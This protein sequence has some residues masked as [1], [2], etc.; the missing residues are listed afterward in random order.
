MRLTTFTLWLLL[1][2]LPSAFV[3]ELLGSWFYGP[4]FCEIFVLDRWSRFG[5]FTS[6]RRVVPLL[7]D[8]GRRMLL[9]P[10]SNCLVGHVPYWNRSLE[11][12]WGRPGSCWILVWVVLGKL[13]ISP[14]FSS[15]QWRFLAGSN[16]GGLPKTCI[17]SLN[18]SPTYIRFQETR[19][20]ESYSY[21]HFASF[22]HSICGFIPKV[23][24]L[25]P[26][27]LRTQHRTAISRHKKG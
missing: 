12:S 9:I 7:Y 17:S 15:E 1:V 3:D 14:F 16:K 5:R 26:A 10:Q 19:S 21:P 4:L 13:L 27:F 22:I 23:N 20:F 24:G 11:I 6:S 8:S 18:N 25:H 2:L